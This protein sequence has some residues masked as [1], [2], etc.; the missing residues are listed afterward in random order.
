MQDSQSKPDDHSVLD[1]GFGDWL[2]SF[3]ALDWITRILVVVLIGFVLWNF[4]AKIG[5]WIP[6]SSRR[7]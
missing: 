3:D 4:R 7:K 2:A 6:G 5:S 1:H